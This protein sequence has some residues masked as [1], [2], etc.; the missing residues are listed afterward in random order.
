MA[1]CSRENLQLL[2]VTKQELVKL[3]EVQA[4]LAAGH[5]MPPP[6]LVQGLFARIKYKGQ[7]MLLLASHLLPAGGGGKPAVAVQ[8]PSTAADGNAALLSVPLTAVSS[9][10]PLLDAHW[11]AAGRQELAQL[12]AAVQQRGQALPLAQAADAAWRK[13]AALRW[14]AQH[15]GQPQQERQALLAG[16]LLELQDAAGVAGMHQQLEAE[17][18]EQQQ[19]PQQP[20]AEQ[21]SAGQQPA[22]QQ[23]GMQHP[24]A[25]QQAYAALDMPSSL[26]PA[27]ELAPLDRA[28]FASANGSLRVVAGLQRSGGRQDKEAGASRSIAPSRRG[29]APAQAHLASPS[30]PLSRQATPQLQQPGG[31]RR[32][33]SRSSHGPAP[34][35]SGPQPRLALVLMRYYTCTGG[36]DGS[37]EWLLTTRMVFV[38]GLR[39]GIDKQAAR[40]LLERLVRSVGARVQD[41][42]INR[43]DH[44]GDYALLGLENA[45]HAAA[46]IEQLQAGDLWGNTQTGRHLFLRPQVGDVE[47]VAGL[48]P[49][50]AAAAHRRRAALAAGAG[51]VRPGGRGQASQGLQRSRSR[52]PGN[53]HRSCSR[54]RRWSSREQ[55]QPER[56]RQRSRSRSISTVR[57]ATR[58]LRPGLGERRAGSP[59]QRM[60]GAPP[61]RQPQRFGSGPGPA[62]HLM[63]APPPAEPLLA[64]VLMS[65]WGTHEW[66]LTGSRV[67]VSGLSSG[68]EPAQVAAD[69]RA[70]AEDAGGTVIH[71]HLAPG[72]H[73][74]D[75]GHL[76][77]RTAREAAMV[78]EHLQHSKVRDISTQHPQ[79]ATTAEYIRIACQAGAPPPPHPVPE[80]PQQRLGPGWGG[81]PGLDDGGPVLD[82]GRLGPGRQ[83][84]W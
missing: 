52:S 55:G 35:P 46:A 28:V 54:G 9:T 51:D 19:Q 42:R 5:S 39:R 61:P 53:G 80:G 47:E 12:Q 76:Q 69:L 79:E 41:C 62:P 77:L 49:E 83:G 63:D 2:L 4:L 70:A 65:H 71:C 73:R 66:L 40:A 48:W 75:K 59:M 74:G 60:P 15:A 50:E 29:A 16:L 18:E 6:N 10:N 13:Q 58:L 38:G 78:I 34:L 1:A 44:R 14:H 8:V 7:Y 64:P 24:T 81:G 17:A 22:P 3:A 21:Q 37:S 67:F 56:Q 57:G 84:R 23:P 45:A 68:P 31:A 11:E 82:D 33:S 25:Q 32:G 26:L 27:E 72:D 43:G 20:A 36:D 30:P